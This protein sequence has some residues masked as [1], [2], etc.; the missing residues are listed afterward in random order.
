[1]EG[2]TYEGMW[3]SFHFK[4][5]HLKMNHE[6]VFSHTETKG[7]QKL[8]CNEFKTIKGHK[9]FITQIKKY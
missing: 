4:H 7:S 5:L 1:M 8:L 6:C 3:G 2:G 9:Y